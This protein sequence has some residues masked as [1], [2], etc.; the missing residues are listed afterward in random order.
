MFSENVAPGQPL[1]NLGRFGDF[2]QPGAI[3]KRRPQGEEAWIT[4]KDGQTFSSAT[5]EVFRGGT[6]SGVV[7]NDRGEPMREVHIETWRRTSN[8]QLEHRHGATTDVAGAYRI[9]AVPAGDHFLV[10]RVWHDTMRQGPR[11]ADASPCSP[12]PPPPPPGAPLRPERIEKP[13][14]AEGDSLDSGAGSGR[15]RAAANHPDDALPDRASWPTAHDRLAGFARTRSLDGAYRFGHLVPG[16]Y[17]IAAVDERRIG[18]W[19]RAAFLEAIAKQA[20]AVRIAPGEPRSL[21]L[22]LQAR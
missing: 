12:L 20:S 1:Q 18:D 4:L 22:M 8:G 3:G 7:S 21:K 16:D 6:I 11:V 5:I 17:F 9:T 2:Y 19:P 14:Y 13:K 15:S 10:A